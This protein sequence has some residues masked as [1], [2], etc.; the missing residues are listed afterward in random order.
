M[1]FIRKKS[2]AKATVVYDI[3]DD[4]V[5]VAFVTTEEK[6]PTVIWSK[7]YPVFPSSSP[8]DDSHHRSLSHS[9]TEIQNEVR[10]EGLPVLDRLGLSRDIA[11][12][13]CVLSPSMHTADAITSRFNQGKTF[14]PSTHHLQTAQD[15]AHKEFINRHQDK[16]TNDVPDH[17][18][19][20][21]LRLSGDGQP[22]SLSRPHMI[23]QLDLHMYIAKAPRELK[24]SISRSLGQLF[25]T[26]NIVFYS[27]FEA[28]NQSLMSADR[29]LRDFLIVIPGKRKTDIIS[30]VSGVID[31]VTSNQIGEDFLI[32]T[33]ASALSRPYHDVRSRIHLHQ[34]KSHHIPSRHEMD[35]ALQEISRRWSKAT[36]EEM[37]EAANGVLPQHLYLV[38]P[39]SRTGTVFQDF[40]K[41]IS[42][43]VPSMK[44]ALVGEN[45]FND[46]VQ[47]HRA[48]DHRLIMS[49]LGSCGY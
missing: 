34:Q 42:R 1:A 32:R 38:L 39:S 31:G 6:L 36:Y 27:G 14:T 11:G 3:N 17:V 43:L 25:H 18:S 29:K 30:T 47:N 9:L 2:P 44:I 26:C 46:F 20:Q 40:S 33:I 15:Q 19:H 16:F 21:I 10:K 5:A 8:D 7:R 28:I 24:R 22:L 23:D 45:D 4:S 37:K 48:G 49:V 12:I 41:D 13:K 35:I